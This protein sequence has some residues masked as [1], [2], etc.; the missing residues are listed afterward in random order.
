MA[1]TALDTARAQMTAAA[2]NDLPDSAF[3]YTEPG[4]TKDADGR[5][6]PRSKR[7][8]PIHDEAHVRAALSRAPQSPYGDRAMP[9]IKAAARKFGISVGG[10]SDAGRSA[11]TYERSWDL[12]DIIVRAGGDG[13]TVE[14]YAAIFDQPAEITDQHG[15]Y[16][17][18]IERS[19]FNRTLSHGIDR[20]GVYYHHGMTIHG[21]PSDLGSVPIGRALDVRPDRRGL[22][23]VTRYNRSDLADAVL[24]SIRNGD[25]RGYSFRGRII[26]SQPRRPPRVRAGAALPVWR[27]MELGLTEYGP[28]PTPAYDDAG[29]LA[30]RSARLAEALAEA[31][32]QLQDFSPPTPHDA[33]P[34]GDPATPTTGPGAEDPPESGH[35]GR[36]R[37]RHLALKRA[38]R[39]LGIVKE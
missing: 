35:S 5:T 3:A 30:V 24:E 25:I 34:G 39:E 9:K 7:H 4:G 31:A 21:T 22:L 6:T 37:Q 32:R 19:A 20:L 11:A 28:T 13:R 23:T 33:D 14:A 38:V 29:I 15:H 10:E 2:I 17:E 26:R 16:L 36:L 12:D 27:H 18:T 1:E 8:F